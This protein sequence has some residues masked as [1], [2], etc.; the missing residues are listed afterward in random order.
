MKIKVREWEK[1]KNSV[2]VNYGPLT[3]SL[4]IAENYV[5]KDS[6][7]T[8]IGDSGW[9][10]DADPVKWPS[11][12]IYAA[13]EW[14]Y[15]VILNKTS[16][17]NSF[18]VV[19]KAWPKDDNPFT[20]AGAPIELQV[21]GRIIPGWKIDQYGLCGLLPQSPVQTDQQATTLTLVPMGGA[22]LRISSFPVVE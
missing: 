3:F 12:E 2:S 19:K 18:T 20:N 13:S 6:K 22:R 7:S 21:K 9:Q 14:N 8:A 5:Q 11:F 15:G 1:N 10:K 16:P 4:K 17:E